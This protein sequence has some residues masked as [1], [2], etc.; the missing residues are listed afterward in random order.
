MRTVI[1]L[2]GD[3]TVKSIEPE[4]RDSLLR[5]FRRWREAQTDL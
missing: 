4:T 1:R 3:L 5:A 2:A